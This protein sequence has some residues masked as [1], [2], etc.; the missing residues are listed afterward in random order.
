MR[1]KKK[2]KK[3]KRAKKRVK[4]GAK[5]FVSVGVPEP[6]KEMIKKVAKRQKMR[7]YQVVEM[8]IRQ[9]ITEQTYKKGEKTYHAG[10]TIDRKI[11]YAF[12]LANSIAQLKMAKSELDKEKVEKYHEMTLNTL[13][14]LATRLN[15]DTKEVESAIDEFLKNPTGINTAKLNDATKILMARIVLGG[16][17]A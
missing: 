7:I 13:N 1:R 8:A 11:W 4:K 14:Q 3:K 10:Y 16:K 17:H 5:R 6:I 15:V 12:K 2:V 9:Y